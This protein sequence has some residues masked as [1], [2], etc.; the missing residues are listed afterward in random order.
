[1]R[2]ANGW[3]RMVLVST[4]GVLLMTAA[5]AATTTRVSLSGAGI[6]GNGSSD[7]PCLSADGRYLAFVSRAGNLVTGDTNY[8]QDVF[9]RDTVAGTTRRVSVSSSGAQADAP[10]YDPAI[11][12]DGRYV[13]FMSGASNLIADDQ[14]IWN[15]VYLH[16]CVSGDTVLVSKSSLDQQSNDE[17]YSPSLSANGRYV[18][19]VSMGDNLVVGDRNNN[20]DVFV[21]DMSL[22]QTFVVSVSSAE[23]QGNDWS[24]GPSISGDGRYI[25]FTSYAT[26]L[27]AGDTNGFLDV[28]VR[29]RTGGTTTRASVSSNGTQSNH[30]SRG[31]FIASAGRYVAFESTA[32]NLVSADLNSASDAFVR[33]LTGGTTTR[34]S[35]SST[36][37]EA[38]FGSGKPVL[39]SD[40]RYVAFA[41]ESGLVVGDTNQWVDVF[42]RDRT[43]STTTRMSTSTAGTQ[44]NSD[45]S[46]PAISATGRF[47]AFVS[48]AD[49]LV[50]GDT[51]GVY[52]VFLRDNGGEVIPAVRVCT[53]R[54]TGIP[55][56]AN[57]YC[58]FTTPMKQASVQNN[59]YIN[60]LKVTESMG[61]FIWVGTK[62]TFNP[63]QNLQPN[64]RYQVKIARA[65]VSKLG[66][67]MAEQKIWNF[68]TAPAAAP[69]MAVS[70]MPTASGAQVTVNLSAAADVTVAIRNLAGREIAVLR[71]GQMPAGVHS[72]LWNGK[73][74][75][76]TTAPGGV[77][78]LQVSARTESGAGC[79]AMTSLRR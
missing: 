14:N 23:L 49:N 16:D 45:S 40:G 55:V 78:L 32:S 7:L 2:P 22:G 1:M 56:T 72:L 35:L 39:S 17:S 64:R 34:V 43:L 10:C 76:G 13:A 62:C 67:R 9:V 29:D 51:N 4:V 65:A 66:V 27:V 6:Q 71:P 42:V 5:L 57:I 12:A 31:A 73:S 20:T 41:S 48:D 63:A 68:T 36:G 30:A 70:A 38:H 33:D 47:V 53:P 74:S 60:G 8:M 37:Q 52:D 58:R 15:D 77:Y 19:F 28:F 11:S 75:S 50:T 25:A 26:N 59:F 3:L 61:T 54:G 24:F 46:T 44:G 79:V 18:A 21:R 69:A